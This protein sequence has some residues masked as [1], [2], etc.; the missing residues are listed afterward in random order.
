MRNYQLEP[1]LTRGGGYNCRHSWSPVSEEL[2]ES[3]DLDRGT[4]AD[5]RKANERARRQ[6]EAAQNKDFVFRFS[7]PSPL[8]ATPTSLTLPDGT[9]SG[10]SAMTPAHA[11]VTVT[12]LR[13]IGGRS[14]LSASASAASLVGVG[15][16]E[17]G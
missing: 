15:Q 4:E 12:A 5:V 3:A 9:S 16:V 17:R 13:R 7:A 2:I 1:V 14:T 6:D 10:P 8:A 11:D